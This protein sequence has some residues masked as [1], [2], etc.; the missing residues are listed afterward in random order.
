MRRDYRQAELD[1]SSVS[2]TPLDQLQTWFLEAVKSELLEANAMTLAT[3]DEHNQPTTRVVLLKEI[4]QEGLVFYT[5]YESRKGREIA[6]NPKVAL[7]FLWLG[8][9]R[10]VR[11][12]GLARRI[13]DEESRAYFQ[14]RPKGSQISAWVSRQ[15]DQIPSRVILEKRYRE[16]EEKYAE[17]TALP[18]PPFWGGYLVEPELVEFWQGRGDR[19]HDRI[20]YRRMDDRW[21]IERLQP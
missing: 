3:V 15:S 16:V 4:R 8:L 11:I 19:L 18:L 1:E 21:Q 7:N 2:T 6:Q 12:E 17:E 13:E 5:N 14:S 20:Q 10:Q 9:E